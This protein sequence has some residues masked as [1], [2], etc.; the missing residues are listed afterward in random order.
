MQM[1]ITRPSTGMNS[2][3]DEDRM[4]ATNTRF[5]ILGL[6]VTFSL[7]TLLIGCSPYGGDAGAERSQQQ[8]EVLQDRIK[9]TQIDR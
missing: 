1:G 5:R 3:A 9:S 6:I 2:H 7:G 8:S 4:K